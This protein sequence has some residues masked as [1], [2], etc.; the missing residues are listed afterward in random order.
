[1]RAQNTGVL[2]LDMENQAPVSDVVVI[3]KYGRTLSHRLRGYHDRQGLV[4]RRGTRYS[5]F[6][7]FN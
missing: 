3:P 5:P 6:L 1:M 2:R 4:I 7:G